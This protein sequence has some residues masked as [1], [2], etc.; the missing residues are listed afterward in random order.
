MQE[1]QSTKRLLW[2]LRLLLVWVVVIFLRLVWLQVLQHDD[3][4]KQAQS[5]QQRLIPVQAERGSILDRT[6]QPLAKSLPAESILVNPKRV[7]DPAV[8]GGLLAPILGLNADQLAEKIRTALR[9]DS[10][11]LWVKRKVTAD[12]A[13]RVRSYRLTEVEFREESRRFY[14][15]GQLA[16]HVLGSVG[17]ANPNDTIER[18]TGGIEMSLDDDLAGQP[19]QMR[20][21][22]DVRQNS[23]DSVMARK[24]DPGA[25]ITL[26]I[27]QNLQYEAEK[28]IARAAIASGSKSGSIVVM[29]P[30]NGEILA[31]ANYPT[32]DPNDPPGPGEAPGARSNLAITTPFEPGSV[33][34][35]ITLSAALETT[36]LRPESMINCGNGVFNLL[37]RVIHDTHA[38]GVL[39]MADVLAQS[40]N[41]GAIQ[42]GL[43]VGDQKLY[44]YV[45]KFGFG[46]KTGI[47]LP[48]ESPGILRRVK[49]WSPTSIGSV[50]MGQEVGVTSL[51]MALAGAA[52]ANGGLLLKPKIILARQKKGEAIEH[53][54][55]EKPER[56]IAPETAILMRQ[57]MEGVILHGTGTRYA[58][59]KGYTAGGKTGSAQIYDLKAHVYTHSYNASFLG[60]AP[61]A[62]PQIVVAVTL[63]GTQ[64]GN[65]GFGGPVAGPVFSKV[66][67]TALRMLDVPKDLPD[68]LLPSHAAS[69][70][71]DLSIADLGSES[72]PSRHVSSNTAPPVQA[73][74]SSSEEA[75]IE[76]GPKDSNLDRRP[77]LTASVKGALVGPKVPNFRGMTLRAVLEE[78]AATGVQIEVLGNGLAR[79]Q[80]PAAG[81]ILA[82]GARVRVQFSR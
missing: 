62:N 27:D 21:Y 56:V 65:A 76:S 73:D 29:N 13:E 40:S 19:G 14:P 20:V 55:D 17:I 5:Q 39:S 81:S 48:G 36:S 64:G 54:P 51:Q 32:Y 74:S 7:K 46:R 58:T 10:G 33:F 44:K 15:H 30:N 80:E 60:F 38:H 2:L 57:M 59:I 82:P 70:D 22:N 37:G 41:I 49:D 1:T 52:V 12:E 8:T 4:L 16:A 50:A 68:S 25:D 42:I 34:K 72:A 69:T 11:F 24:P 77:F 23:Y 71:D 63:N 6:G 45:L 67:M 26:T 31:M 47:E 18:G 35:V 53:F 79:N 9:R 61:V 75:S 66:A 28:E 3:L 78:S 43:K